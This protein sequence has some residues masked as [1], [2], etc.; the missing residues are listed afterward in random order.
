MEDRRILEIPS[1]MNISRETVVAM[2]RQMIVC[3]CKPATTFERCN[4]TS[5]WQALR[6]KLVMYINI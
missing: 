5:F 3:D 1:G 6:T 4:I 2:N